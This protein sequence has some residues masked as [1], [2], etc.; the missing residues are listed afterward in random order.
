MTAVRV[1]L[2]PMGC[3]LEAISNFLF[4]RTFIN[5]ERVEIIV[6]LWIDTQ[7]IIGLLVDIFVICFPLRFIRIRI[8][9]CDLKEMSEFS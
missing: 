1:A 4:P 7:W 8:L 2:T 9:F 6:A 3:R 5:V